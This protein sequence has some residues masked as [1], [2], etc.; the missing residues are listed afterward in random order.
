MKKLLFLILFFLV[1]PLGAG[2]EPR[3]VSLFNGV[4]L[5][6]WDAKPDHFQFF[7]IR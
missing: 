3:F 2:G 6:G 4:D 7:A 1:S 5:D